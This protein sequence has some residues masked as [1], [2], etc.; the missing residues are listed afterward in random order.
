[1]AHLVG[2]VSWSE[3]RWSR[4]PTAEERKRSSHGNVRAGYVGDECLN[5]SRAPETIRDGWKYGAVE[6]F[7]QKR[8]F[9]RGGLLFLWSSNPQSGASLY[10]VLA[11]VE[12][13]E[14]PQRW[15]VN[16]EVGTLLFN[17]RYPALT[18]LGLLFERPLPIKPEYLREGDKQKTRPGQSCGCYIDDDSAQRIL[19]DAGGQALG[20]FNLYWPEHDG[21]S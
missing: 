9:S 1:M 15:W 20:I 5:L 13:L 21:I 10:G 12:Q 11:K 6:K 18:D 2:S 4:P 17:L 14:A 19:L 3:A 16:E 8:S 7:N